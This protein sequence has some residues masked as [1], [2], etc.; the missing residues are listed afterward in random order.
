MNDN[1]R[2]AWNIY[3]QHCVRTRMDIPAAIAAGMIPKQELVDGAIYE[4]HCRNSSTAKWDAAQEVFSYDRNKW[5]YVYEESIVHP[6]DDEGYD[7]FVPVKRI[8]EN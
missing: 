6:E 5:G 2:L 1:Q 3:H 7:I 4:G 8:E